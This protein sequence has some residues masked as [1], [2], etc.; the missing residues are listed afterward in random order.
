MILQKPINLLIGALDSQTLSEKY[1]S[2][3]FFAPIAFTHIILKHLVTQSLKKEKLEHLIPQSKLLK[4][5][6]SQTKLCNT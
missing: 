4:H 2:K 3:Q 5:L 6:P 1:S